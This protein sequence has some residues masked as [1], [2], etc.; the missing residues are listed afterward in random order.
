MNRNGIGTLGPLT[1]LVISM[2][3]ATIDVAIEAISSKMTQE[4]LSNSTCSRMR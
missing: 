1:S 3:T 2:A 4:L